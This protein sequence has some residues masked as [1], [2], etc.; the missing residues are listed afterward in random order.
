M[1]RI[2]LIMLGA[3]LAGCG[4]RSPEPELLIPVNVRC[5]TCTDHIR[6]ENDAGNPA[7]GEQAFSLYILEAKGPG[8]DEI[9]SITEYFL[10]FAEPKTRFTRP[11]S[12]HVQTIGTSG[13]PERR[14]S[15]ELTATMDRATHRIELPDAWIDQQNG[16]WHDKA[17]DS[18][19][20]TCRL[21]DR[22]EGGLTASFFLERT[23]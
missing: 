1:Y 7:V 21:L 14:T 16:Q 6:C 20:G 4:A 10:Q 11:L 23:Q 8:N 9:T 5:S 12:V 15:M 22:Q 2:L 19:R 17:G 13:Q 18:L 3:L